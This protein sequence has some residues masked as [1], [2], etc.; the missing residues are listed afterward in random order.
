MTF[1]TCLEQKR[2]RKW[3]K[4]HLRYLVYSPVFQVLSWRNKFLSRLELITTNAATAT[5]DL[6][7]IHDTFRRKYDVKAVSS[8]FRYRHCCVSVI[9]RPAGYLKSPYLAHG[10]IWVLGHCGTVL[11][12][13]LLA[14]TYAPLYPCV[15]HNN[16]TACA[17]CY[18]LR[19]ESLCVT[20]VSKQ[21]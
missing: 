7:V 12:F 2:A 1:L 10:A 15:H 17:G 19:S 3:M 13:A 9:M 5:N 11:S 14:Q 8:T 6:S 20:H 18:W 16:L 4:L 21:Q